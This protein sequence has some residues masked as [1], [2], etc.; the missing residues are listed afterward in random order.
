MKNFYMLLLL[1][2]VTVKSMSQV[3]IDS[4]GTKVAVDSSKWTI[5]GSNIFNKNSGNVGI[6][7]SAPAAQLHTTGTV[8]FAGVG[9]NTINTKIL[10]TDNSGNLTTRTVSS[11]LSGS[12]ITSLN[13]MTGSVQT[14]AAG[15]TGTDFTISSA[16]NVHTFNLPVASATNSG[17]LSAA[18]WTTF[19][20]KTGVVTATTAAAVTTALTTATIRNT[21]A[22]WNANLLQ[23][24]AV[25]ATAPTSGQ[26][27]TWSGSTWAPAQLL[28]P[29]TT[30]SNTNAAPNTLTTTV[31]G[32]TGT[33]VPIVNSV[34]NASSGN[35][36]TTTV[37]GITGS[38]ISLVNSVSNNLSGTNLTTSING[39][40][41]SAVSLTGLIP[42]TTNGLSLSGNTITSTVNG[43][44]ANTNAVSGVSNNLSGS[45]LTTSVNGI[46]GSVNLSGLVPAVTHTISIAGNI[47]TSVVNGVSANSN[48]VTGVANAS[49]GNSLSTTIN[50]IT[51]TN[52]PIINTIS[53]TS[54]ANTIKT[55]VN[56]IEGSTVNIINSNAL[57]QNV[58]NQ[59]IS[60]VNGIASSALTANITGDVTGNLGTATVSKINGSP[61]G[62]TT[63][64]TSGQVLSW[65]GSNWAPSNAAPA[66]T[67]HTM[68]SAANTITSN[69]NGI[70]VT[71]SAVNS[72]G[73]A[74]YVNSL[75]TSVNGVSSVPVNIINTNSLTLNSGSLTSSV[76]GLSAN[77]VNV[78]A[79][80]G[81]GLT[82]AAG[83]VELGGTL[84]KPTIINT[85][86]TNTISLGGLQTGSSSDSLLVVATGGVVKRVAAPASFPQLLVDARRTTAY[87]PGTAFVTLVYN[88]T[89]I[90]TGSAYNTSTGLFT[91]PATG[92]YE[93]ILNNG[94]NWDASN[95]QVVNQIVVNNVIDMEKA[96][97]NNTK[98][99]NASAT[100]SG[101]TIVNITAGQQVRITAGD[102]LGRTI[103]MTG[104][105]QH[106]LKIIR[107]L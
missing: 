89:N 4:K 67:T 68:S 63:G 30:V 32:I 47:L 49:S 57:S 75:I 92:L 71:A 21:A 3:V 6:G 1:L 37:N 70:A 105:G 23:G 60:T 62:T 93:I 20:N 58:T 79:A 42:A 26:V 88:T 38:A 34:S 84:S 96:I 41:G 39:I 8:M 94:Y 40:T 72:V 19:N 74:S 53:N 22:Y 69:V 87:S 107:L 81:N 31:N 33:G 76:N 27:L 50:G 36:L 73:N 45:T 18:N 99:S 83:I 103:P 102:E 2:C 29:A 85:G 86:S 80:A 65:N 106:V 52:V 9:T 97:S 11:L 77:A 78:L 59:L 98:D 55:T 54:S 13:G 14:F 44:A 25:A 46:T 91:A 66:I 12:A 100:V 82:A 51:G 17:K 56:G 24:N 5:S 64:A 90:N 95:S 10:T 35:N 48:A 61:L 7:T 104:A 43:V 16:A 28:L 101:S 15:T